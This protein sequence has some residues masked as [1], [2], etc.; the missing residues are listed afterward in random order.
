[1]KNCLVVNLFGAPCTGKST[2][3]AYIFSRLKMHGINVELVTE[4]VKDMVWEEN[5]TCLNNQPYIFGQQSYRLSRC[6]DKVDVIVTDSPLLLSI[7]YN[8]DK[9]IAEPLNELVMRVF[10]SYNN[11]N[12]VLTSDFL[13]DPHGRIHNEEECEV[14][15]QDIV[16]LLTDN[17]LYYTCVDPVDDGLEFCVRDIIW[18]LHPEIVFDAF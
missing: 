16:K 3:A 6:A 2:A 1:M 11:L 15:Q 9:T 12:Y 5:K 4:Y 10:N 8:P 13:Y 17:E 18:S 14:I 7:L